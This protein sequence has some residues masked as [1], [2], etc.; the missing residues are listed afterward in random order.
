MSDRPRISEEVQE[1]LDA[2]RVSNVDFYAGP[3]DGKDPEDQVTRRI[4][5]E[6]PDAESDVGADSGVADSS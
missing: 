3:V 4:P 6:P 1:L 5:I 2:G